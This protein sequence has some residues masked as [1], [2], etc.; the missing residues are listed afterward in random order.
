MTPKQKTTTQGFSSGSKKNNL[1]S[2]NPY[3]SKGFGSSSAVSSGGRSGE[4][5][6]YTVGDTV[7][8]SKFGLGTV[9][10]MEDKGNEYIVTV[11]FE[12]FGP[13]KLK[14]TFARLTKA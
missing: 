5:P 14:S 4:T 13:R 12:D 7:E 1:F 9:T 11:D 3:I 2:D 8:H 10:A 6:D